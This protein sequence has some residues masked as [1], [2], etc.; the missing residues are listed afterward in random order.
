MKIIV[1]SG[2][3]SCCVIFHWLVVYISRVLLNK[4]F[5]SIFTVLSITVVSVYLKKFS[6]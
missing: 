4:G 6:F 2:T 3:V 1:H 5:V